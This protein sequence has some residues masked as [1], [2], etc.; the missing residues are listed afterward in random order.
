MKKF[1]IDILDYLR[2]KLLD[3]KCTEE[4]MAHLAKVVSENIS[5]EATIS[6]IARHYGQSESNVRNIIARNYVGK[7]KRRV[8]YNFI[9]FAKLAPETWREHLQHATTSQLDT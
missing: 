2:N 7:P 3:D 1:L 9:K 5:A 6:D 4:E 8:Y